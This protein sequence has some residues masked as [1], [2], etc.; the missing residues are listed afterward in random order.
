MD[1][2][3]VV[4]EGAQNSAPGDSEQCWP[5]DAQA[6][7]TYLR[8][9]GFK[10]GVSEALRAI[11]LLDHLAKSKRPRN[12]QEAALW[13][14]PVLCTTARQQAALPDHLEAFARRV[15]ADEEWDRNRVPPTPGNGGAAPD[16][17]QPPSMS[18]FVRTLILC[19]AAMVI[20]IVALVRSGWLSQ[21]PSPAPAPVAANA[22]VT[23]KAASRG[24]FANV[25]LP[26]LAIRGAASLGLPLLCGLFIVRWRERKRPVLTRL[27][28]D[29]RPAVSLFPDSA[30]FDLFTDDRL[31][32]FGG[33]Q[34][35]AG[36]PDSVQALRLALQGMRAHRYV[37]Y[38]SID[39]HASLQA[40][41][42]AAGAPRFVPGRRLRLPDYP[43][44]VE[45]RASRD[46]LPELGSALAKCMDLEDVHHSVYIFDSDPRY[47]RTGSRGDAPLSLAD[48]ESRFNDDTLVILSDGECLLDPFLGQMLPWTAEL[49][50]WNAVVLL[51]PVPRHRWTWRERHFSNAGITVLPASHE[52]LLLLGALMRTHSKPP[53]LPFERAAARPSLLVR[54]GSRALRWHADAVPDEEGRDQVIE[55]IAMELSR[56]AFE[57]TCVLALFPELRPDL[58]LHVAATLHDQNGA[59]LINGRDY[60]A[61]SALPWFRVGRMP[62]W[63]RVTLV[64]M[65]PESRIDQARTLY[66]G[67]LVSDEKNK[68][69]PEEAESVTIGRAQRALKEEIAHRPA[70][71]LHDALFLRFMNKGDLST[72]DLEVSRSVVDKVREDQALVRRLAVPVVCLMA[73]LITAFLAFYSVRTPSFLVNLL[74]PLFT[75]LQVA[76]RQPTALP[77][78]EGAGIA[79]C[80][81]GLVL[82]LW[83]AFRGGGTVSRYGFAPFLCAAALLLFEPAVISANYDGLAM[84]GV[85]LPLLLMTAV[86]ARPEAAYFEAAFGS[87]W[88]GRFIGLLLA[89]VGAC[90]QTFRQYLAPEAGMV[91]YV[92]GVA[93]LYA[94]FTRRS[95]LD[96]FAGAMAIQVLI[97]GPIYLFS[98]SY[99]MIWILTLAAPHLGSVIAICSHGKTRWA[100]I[101]TG[102]ACLAAMEAA[103]V[104]LRS[105]DRVLSVT[106]ITLMFAISLVPPALLTHDRLPR[107][108]ASIVGGFCISCAGICGAYLLDVTLVQHRPSP[109]LLA[110]FLP[111]TENDWR[112]LANGVAGLASLALLPAARRW[113]IERLE[114]GTVRDAMLRASRTL[115]PSLPVILLAGLLL[116][117]LAPRI[118]PTNMIVDLC[119]LAL[120]L[121]VLLATKCG[122][123]MLPVLLLG[124]SPLVITISSSWLADDYS[125]AV[126]CIVLFLLLTRPYAIERVRGLAALSLFEIAGSLSVFSVGLNQTLGNPDFGMY[127]S[128]SGF[129]AL[130]MVLMGVA[131]ARPARVFGALVI[132]SVILINVRLALREALIHLGPFS[133]NSLSPLT[134]LAAFWLGY[135]FVSS[136]DHLRTFTTRWK[137]WTTNLGMVLIALVLSIA[138]QWISRETNPTLLT[139][140]RLV[141]FADLITPSRELQVLGAIAIVLLYQMAPGR[142]KAAWAFCSLVLLVMMKMVSLTSAWK[143]DASRGIADLL[144][145]TAAVTAGT[146]CG[147]WLSRWM[148]SAAGRDWIAR[149][150]A[151]RWTPGAESGRR[152]AD[153]EWFGL[154]LRQ[155]LF[156]A[157]GTAVI[158]ALI[159][160][161]PPATTSGLIALGGYCCVSSLVALYF[162]FETGRQYSV[163]PSENMR[164]IFYF[165]RVA[166]VALW[167]LVAGTLVVAALFI[168]S[169]TATSPFKQSPRTLPDYALYIPAVNAVLV[170]ALVRLLS[171]SNGGVAFKWARGPV[172]AMCVA[173]AAVVVSALLM[174]LTRSVGPVLFFRDPIAKALLEFSAAQGL[175]LGA[176]VPHAYRQARL[177]ASHEPEQK[178]A[179]DHAA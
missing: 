9:T 102:V 104:L 106:L 94:Q 166:Q 99:P 11:G 75:P 78:L 21:A 90:M 68:D 47:L 143:L 121:T 138:D 124:L 3:P 105:D 100:P 108:A 151:G 36:T 73:W 52:G 97:L 40:T 93:L 77:L 10:I 70:S 165:Q 133:L 101:A 128:L 164:V 38:R 49:L 107:D 43:V 82:G 158:F 173:V 45:R 117:S 14:A 176:Y 144:S 30:S 66:S 71:G 123:R 145:G 26:T 116:S 147:F 139:I 7:I 6:L 18:R 4:E 175:F 111:S 64:Q 160:D 140:P 59:S 114:G 46:H 174:Q 57:L 13:L 129:S 55:A 74:Q 115:V 84:L 32:N 112:V 25:D 12:V 159:L 98:D 171:R 127:S 39:L 148:N 172:E 1:A 162:A 136:P 179:Y 132:Y 130:F 152:Q 80:V 65:L 154:G 41:I 33:K 83:R 67:W 42:A 177:K 19:A 126:T 135:Y 37:P 48:I 69:A 24:L 110:T 72:L 60:A 178:F 27:P 170:A 62:N 29:G 120:P 103:R 51:T 141:D 76:L 22:Q 28:Y 119:P 149:A 85:V 96:T 63:L 156:I 53:R 15:R 146:L 134:C 150:S 35:E 81:A 17:P 113:L 153:A 125:A 118:G 122:P 163:R 167:G 86:S 56:R 109:G 54:E 50:N 137:G 131:G 92:A 91:M 168:A 88:N 34:S 44:L 58:T 5:R 16:V 169:L 2:G 89:G 161:F 20:L 23:A 157:V 142:L 155:W 87:V 61:M 79:I 8:E 95:F 31:S